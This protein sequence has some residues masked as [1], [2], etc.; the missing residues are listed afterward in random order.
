RLLL[1]VRRAFVELRQH[2]CR[3]WRRLWVRRRPISGAGPRTDRTWFLDLVKRPFASARLHD[4][5]AL[6]IAVFAQKPVSFVQRAIPPGLVV[7][8]AVARVLGRQEDHG[9]AQP[10]PLGQ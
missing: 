8:E 4:R 2:G 3:L 10:L 1:L 5:R 9:E 6:E 7:E